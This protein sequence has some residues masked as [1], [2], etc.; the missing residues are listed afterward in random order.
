MILR[1][2]KMQSLLNSAWNKDDSFNFLEKIFPQG[3]YK[4]VLS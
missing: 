3:M 4:Y 2:Q 1:W